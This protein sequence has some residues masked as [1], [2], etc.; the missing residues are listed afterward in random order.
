[1]GDTQPQS[2]SNDL[3]GELIRHAEDFIAQESMA[4]ALSAVCRDEEAWLEAGSDIDAF[5]R[6]RRIEVPD[7]LTV[8]PLTW[9]GVGKPAPDFTLFTIRLTR[10]RT[11]WVRDPSTQRYRKE[12]YCIGFEIIPRH[13]SPIG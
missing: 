12:T 8:R 2:R 1:M 10:C 9:P 13:I 6:R 7:D 3:K 4:L 5:L 11:V